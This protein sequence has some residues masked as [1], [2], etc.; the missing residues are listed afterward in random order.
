MSAKV[1]AKGI[2]ASIVE[3]FALDG[4]YGIKQYAYDKVKGL[5]N[6]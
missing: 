2:G 4:Y 1:F 5:L 3:G 6:N